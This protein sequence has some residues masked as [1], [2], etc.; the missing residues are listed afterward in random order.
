MWR[1]LGITLALVVVLLGPVVTGASAQQFDDKTIYVE[2]TV[3]PY[4]ELLCRTSTSIA[5]FP[6]SGTAFEQQ[7]SAPVICDSS[8]NVPVSMSIDFAPLKHDTLPAEIGTA[9]QM[10]LGENS[11]EG[12]FL[13]AG[14]WDG[15]A[16]RDYDWQRASS[17]TMAL[18]GPSKQTH[19]FVVWGKLGE[20]DE[21]P[22]GGYSTEIV[23]TISG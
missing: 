23:V 5:V 22:A 3:K 17:G 21:Q 15:V 18:P 20:V 16:P 19:W 7:S 12:L 4:A 8:Q 2:A 9:V 11:D 14:P 13:V 6:F 1:A 10:T